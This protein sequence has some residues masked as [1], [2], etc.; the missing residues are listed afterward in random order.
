MNDFRR[1]R[2]FPPQCFEKGVD[3]LLGVRED[4]VNKTADVEDLSSHSQA[5]CQFRN[6]GPEADPLN[7][8]PYFDFYG[9][10]F[11]QCKSSMVSL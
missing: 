2:L 6:K 10:F 1:K 7:D 4:N 11:R 3:S 9:L 8:S 5:V